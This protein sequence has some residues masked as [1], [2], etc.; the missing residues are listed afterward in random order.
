MS[1]QQ[2]TIL[3]NKMLNLCFIV[4]ILTIFFVIFCRLLYFFFYKKKRLLLN[5]VD[6]ASFVFENAFLTCFCS[7][8]QTFFKKRIWFHIHHEYIKSY[9]KHFLVSMC[10]ISKIIQFNQQDQ[11]EWC[12]IWSRIWLH[13]RSTRDQYDWDRAFS[14]LCCIV[15]TFG[16]MCVFIF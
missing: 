13:F 9:V 4:L 5:N 14:F 2:I 10:L 16:G 12:H 3:Q 8:M 11:H 7:A 1:V 15:Y 6:M